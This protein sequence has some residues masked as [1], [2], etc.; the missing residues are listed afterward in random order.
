MNAEMVDIPSDLFSD[1][2]VSRLDDT[3][4]RAITHEDRV[5]ECIRSE[6]I[7]ADPRFQ[8]KLD[9]FLLQLAHANNKILSL[10]NSR[11]RILAHQV[12]STHRIVN[13]LN[14]RFL[15]ADEVGLGKTIEAGL[16]IKELIFRYKY[17]RILIVAPASLLVQWQHEM[18]EKFGEHFDVI[19]RRAIRRLRRSIAEGENPWDHITKAI[20]SID[21]VK[22]ASIVSELEGTKWDAVIIDEAHR[23]RRD[24][25]VSTQA[26]IVGEILSASAK[27]FLLLTATP[28]RGKLEELYYLVRLADR[29]LLG[30]FQ[31]F[32]NDYCMPE[33]D[34]SRLKEKLSAVVIRRTKKEVG[35]FTNRFARTIRFDFYSDERALYDATTRYV[36]EEFNRATATGNRAIGFVMTVFQKLLDSSSYALLSAL[37]NRRKHLAVL[38]EKADRHASIVENAS[39]RIE[40]MDMDFFEDENPD[41]IVKAAARKTVS[42]MKEEIAT[43]DSLIR[44]AESVRLNKKGEKLLEMIEVLKGKGYSKFLIFTQF[45]TTQDYLVDL[46]KGYRVAVFNGSMD[47][48]QKEDAIKYFQEDAEVLICTEAGGEGRNMQFC[49]VLFNYD[50]PWS[51]LKIEQRIGR[52]HRFG[53]KHDV[54]IY[55]FS[56]KDTVAERVLDV[57]TRKLQLFE[58]SIG[59][60]DIM[61]GQIEDEVKLSS[62]FMELSSGKRSK[63]SV[64]K[65]IDRSVALARAS[66]EKLSDLTVARKMDFNYDEYYRITQKDRTYSN[67]QLEHFIERA[68]ETLPAIDESLGRKN[69]RDEIYPVRSVPDVVRHHP[70]G[71]FDSEKALSRS[72]LEFF[73][74]GHPLIERVITS[75][76]EVSFGG[77]TGVMEIEYERPFEGMVFYY[78]ATYRSV[79]ETR[80]IIPVVADFDGKAFSFEMERIERECSRNVG[81]RPKDKSILESLEVRAR[82]MIDKLAESARER[83]FEKVEHKLWDIREHLDLTIDPEIEKIK[84]SCDRQIKELESQLERQEMQMKCFG[85]EMRGAISRTKNRMSEAVRDRDLMLATYRRRLGVRCDIEMVSAGIIVTRDIS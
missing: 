46:L 17:R 37:R 30:P 22:S 28:F 36:A 35:G 23:L 63:Q 29:S 24:A 48:D 9:A 4:P 85:R 70:F 57:L 80:E 54:A 45:R 82:S 73:A 83:I 13:A 50:L 55:N 8:I 71:T 77:L 74:F 72:D 34:L 10:S 18:E 49:S 68:R 84:E 65:E 60:P 19:D 33:S 42:E 1:D 62:L 38:L 21:F 32:Y 47:K 14:Q 51:P 67:K 41:E 69:I 66:Y 78:L 7:T 2:V 81:K 59:T 40:S 64:E 11:T 12:E 26:Y 15:I 53:Q 3:H 76:Q 16:V 25:Q 79:S 56:T 31:S 52:I 39:M 5:L 27:A 58:D 44:L 61:L 75:C 43:I 20:C 6:G